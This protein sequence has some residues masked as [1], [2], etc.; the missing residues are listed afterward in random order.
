[1]LSAIKLS[2]VDQ[3]I[4]DIRPDLDG[5]DG[6]SGV[7][8]NHDGIWFRPIREDWPRHNPELQLVYTRGS[9]GSETY[10]QFLRYLRRIWG[11]DTDD[12]ME[13][14]VFDTGYRVRTRTSIIW[15]E[16]GSHS[17]AAETRVGPVIHEKPKPDPKNGV[18]YQV[19][20]RDGST[21]TVEGVHAVDFREGHAFGLW[22]ENGHD[23]WGAD[24]DDVVAF[25]FVR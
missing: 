9:K 18:T 19:F 23:L 25:K 22:D 12:L 6:V 2:V 14:E 1:M 7:L 13:L 17:Y 20:L 5:A 3:L 24:A 8:F 10:E 16:E 4:R 15:N 11:G 21:A